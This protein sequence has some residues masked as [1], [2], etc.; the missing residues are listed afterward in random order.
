VRE[1]II[2]GKSATIKDLLD[3]IR[4]AAK[5]DAN[6]L[7]LGETGVGKELA[8]RAIH[9]ESSRKDK[10]FVKINCANLSD[11]LLESELFGHKK[12]AYTGAYIDKPGLIEEAQGGVFFFD[13]IG[14]ITPYIQAKLLEAVEQKKI[15]RV[16]EN[17]F[18]SIDT[19]FIFA[20]NKDL[21]SLV[22]KRKFR[23][24]LFYRIYILTFYIPPLRERRID[25]PL[26]IDYFVEKESLKRT[27]KIG[28]TPE[29]INKMCEYTYPGNVRE[30]E[31]I[32]IRACELASSETIREEDISF[33]SM[34]MRDKKITRSKYEL[35]TIMKVLIECKGNKTKAARE[36]GISRVHLY[37]LLDIEGKNRSF[38]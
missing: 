1:P 20:T 30:L 15:R 32:L 27:A 12:G 13:E 8:A 7:I 22:A 17:Y 37:R 26:L 9:C 10:P 19:R 24:D 34:V 28:I 2:I 14:D 33:G 35:D 38:L 11:N 21:Y 6:V 5:S 4:K 25:I 3:F 29:A 16:G 36:L 31:N 18:R 23:Q